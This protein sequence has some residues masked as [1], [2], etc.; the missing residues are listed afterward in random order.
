MVVTTASMPPSRTSTLERA[1]VVAAHPAHDRDERAGAAAGRR[2]RRCGRGRAART[3][4]SSSMTLARW[5]RPGAPIEHAGAQHRPRT[6]GRARSHALT[7]DAHASTARSNDARSCAPGRT[8]SITSTGV[9]RRASF[10]RIIKSPAARG[11]P[12][13]HVA[14][15]VAG[16][17]VAEREELAAR[18]DPRR[19]RAAWSRS[20]SIAAG[21]GR[22]HDVV[23][24]RVDDDLF[25]AEHA[26]RAARRARTDRRPSRAADRPR[27]GR[28]DRS[29][30][31]T[32]RAPS[33]PACERREQ[34]PRR[35]GG[36]RRTRRRPR[37]VGEPR[38]A[39]TRR[40]RRRGPR[41]RPAAVPSGARS[42]REVGRVDP[43]PDARAASSSSPADGEHRRA[44]PARGCAP[45]TK[46]PVAA[47]TSDQ[48]R[49]VSIERSEPGAFAG[50]GTAVEDRREHVGRAHAAHHRLRTTAPAGARAPT[51]PATLTSSGTT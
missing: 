37:R 32:R 44:A 43:H 18:L 7:I 27:S 49:R 19:A 21:L 46:R 34:E 20:R 51:A 9:R 4:A 47:P 24:A 26:P 45:P 33:S 30:S 8:S 15:V 39:S 11:R 1:A 38:G 35:R 14:Q 25:G 16:R 50:T 42:A 31:G 22:R 3:T 36:R 13:V 23:H 6:A 5:R 2:R 12:P 41:R 17:V 10:W 28:A 29:G 48:P 40:R